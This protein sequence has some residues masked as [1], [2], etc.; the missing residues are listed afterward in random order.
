MGT[1]F[2]T[3][4]KALELSGRFAGRI[5]GLFSEKI[6]E[7]LRF[8]FRGFCGN[9]VQQKGGVKESS[10]ILLSL[11]TAAAF[12]CSSTWEVAK[13]SS[14]SGV[15]DTKMQTAS[16]QRGGRQVTGR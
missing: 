11:E 10:W 2:L 13:G 7:K 5:A 6:S 14:V 4:R 1:T 15:A 16:C 12:L 8:K 3:A 9:F